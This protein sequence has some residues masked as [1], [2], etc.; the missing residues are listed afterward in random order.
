MKCI[1]GTHRHLLENMAPGRLYIL[2]WWGSVVETTEATHSPRSTHT[3]LSCASPVGDTPLRNS[4]SAL[5]GCSLPCSNSNHWWL[6]LESCAGAGLQLVTRHR[7]SAPES[8]VPPTR[9]SNTPHR[10]LISPLKPRA[11]L[12]SM[13]G[14]G[15]G[16]AEW[17]FSCHLGTGQRFTEDSAPVLSS[18]SPPQPAIILG[19][20]IMHVHRVDSA[21]GHQGVMHSGWE[22]KRSPTFTSQPPAMTCRGSLIKLLLPSVP[23]LLLCKIGIVMRV[24]EKIHPK[25]LC[26]VWHAGDHFYLH[27]SCHTQDLK[28]THKVSGSEILK[29]NIWPQPM[30]FQL[31]QSPAIFSLA[32]SW[33][34]VSRVVHLEHLNLPA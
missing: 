25:H 1:W 2:A 28:V 14:G 32:L 10:K 8:W 17:R 4:N 33:C 26:C 18:S 30:S 15:A 12:A 7:A 23:Q 11:D 19:D 24:H 13:D 9:L 31:P 5:Q 29:S 27:I 21:N 20:S 3:L 34:P 22:W 6:W 16:G